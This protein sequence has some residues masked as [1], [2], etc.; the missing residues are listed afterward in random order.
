MSQAKEIF[1]DALDLAAEDRDAFI[2]ERCSGDAALAAEVRALIAASG[3]ADDVFGERAGPISDVHPGDRVGPYVLEE[4]IGE[5]GFAVVWRA[6]Q[7][8]PI[9]RVVALKILK[10][11]LETKHVLARFEAER[12]ALA[13]MDHPNIA[14]VLDGGV[15]EQGRPWFTMELVEG[16]P[17]TE[18]AD[19][20]GLRKNERLAIA[21]DV[22]RAVHHAHQKGVVHRDLKPSNILVTEVD[23]RAVPKVIDFGIAKAIQSDDLA[24]STALT[25]EGQVVGTP[26]YMSPEQVDGNG[27]V[28]TR[29]DVY[30]LGVLLYELLSGARPFEDETLA[31]AGLAEVLRIIREV[32]PPRPSSRET[33]AHVL[34]RELRGDLDWIVMCC[35]EKD[36]ERRYGSVGLLGDEL[37]R[38][39]A[40]EPVMAGPPDFAY[41]ASKFARRHRVELLFASAIAAIVVVGSIV[42]VVLMLRAR[43]AEALARTE[44]ARLDQVS[45]FYESIIAGASPEVS[46]GQDTALVM[47]ILEDAEER[48][49]EEEL[50]ADPA[51]ER[52]VRRAIGGAYHGLG[53]HARAAEQ[54]R[55][56]VELCRGLEPLEEAEMLRDLGSMLLR[57]GDLEGAAHPIEK[58]ALTLRTHGNHDGPTTLRAETTLGVLRRVEGKLD[59]AEAILRANLTRWTEAH[60]ENHE[61]SIETLNNLALVLKD[62]GDAES[63]QESTEFL[64]RAVELQRE[65][66]APTHPTRLKALNNLGESLLSQGRRGEALPYLEE[67]LD[68]K[69]QVL[70]EGHRSL[71]IGLNN[72][73]SL[74]RL[75][76]RPEEGRVHF[77]R[78]LAMVE[79]T[80]EIDTPVAIRLRFNHALC[81]DRC[82]E[83]ELALAG[84]ERCRELAT[85]AFG[86]DSSFTKLI[87]TT[88]AWQEV[89][90]GRAEGAE[91]RLVAALETAKAQASAGT[92]RDPGE[93]GVA[94]VRVGVC[95][96][97]LG[98]EAEGRALV[99]QGLAEIEAAGRAAALSNWVEIART[100]L[101][102]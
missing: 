42:A 86:A 33:T 38:H 25:L 31:R 26:A 55:Q 56:A 60:G 57:A 44:V 9:R 41:R 98:R 64:T 73:A 91:A 62:R 67:A 12:G 32:E 101:E 46:Q 96:M 35:L 19:R 89:K 83:P 2:D 95:R 82:G 66:L 58:A 39:L 8:Q 71:L 78:G 21:V 7:E 49:D 10:P 100:A 18:Y 54:L 51:V 63:I 47:G 85:E 3:E 17:I 50:D 43:D 30:A 68:L 72:L 14:K 77:E 6:S 93:V 94:K 70:P 48:I 13:L 1:L 37:E 53:E 52:A 92:L 5:G 74:L 59:E 11:G 23:G 15:T 75:E 36:R 29:A 99:E 90:L 20:A 34:P 102:S 79:A 22:C 84:Y 28:D 45:R 4:P 27:D 69:I 80:D 81:V 88:C 24:E 40:G 61:G 76:G 65:V 16:R 97:K 87:D